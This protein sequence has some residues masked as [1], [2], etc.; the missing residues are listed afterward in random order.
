MGR[1]V[2]VDAHYADHFEEL[3]DY[4]DPSDPA[5]KQ[6]ENSIP[7]EASDS[8]TGIWPKLTGGRAPS[9]LKR[10]DPVTPMGA[11]TKEDIILIME[12]LG[13][14]KSIQASSHM[15]TYGY[16]NTDD[17]RQTVYA[18]AYT[19]YV[20]DNIADPDEGIY[21]MIPVP[22]NDPIESAELIDR[23]GRERG[24]AGVCMVSQGG[25]EPPLGNRKYDPIY[26]AAERAGQPIIFHGGT[27]GLDQFYI[28]GYST[29]LETHTLG[30]VWDNMA[31]IVS[32]VAQGKPDKFPNLE[33]IFQE[34]GVSY[35]AHMMLRMDT[36][37]LRRHWEASHLKKR[38]SE[39]MLDFYY[40]TQPLE[41]PVNKKHLEYILEIAGGADRFM[42]ATDWPH[43]DFDAPSSITQLP[44]LSRDEKDK[45]LGKNAEEVF[46]I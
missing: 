3:V 9:G 42:F 30:F 10:D 46:G 34:A 26:D 15:L 17:R 14:D 7:I 23:V 37:Y 35:V 6:F 38:P 41:E 4:I 31:Q 39:Y 19:D 22:Y 13:I 43:P 5:R 21:V 16:M 11:E 24:V 45:I 2:D 29:L 1:I 8:T 25:P 33:F 20:L 12:E 40:G 44:F 36:E 27:T 28:G 18:N 32:V